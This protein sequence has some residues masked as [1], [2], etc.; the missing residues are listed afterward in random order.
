MKRPN[1]IRQAIYTGLILFFAV[2][3]AALTDSSAGPVTEGV[4]SISSSSGRFLAS[5]GT[6]LPFGFAF[7]AGMVAA[8]N[9]CGFAMLPAYLALF[10][11]DEIN[12]PV[13]IDRGLTRPAIVGLS[14]T[15]GFITTF[16]SF[17]A[18]IGLGAVQLV[19]LF[20]WIGLLVGVALVIAGAYVVSGGSIYVTGP[21]RWSTSIGVAGTRSIRTYF[22]FGIAYGIASLSCT[23][24]IFLAVVGNT[25]TAETWTQS[26]TQF[27]LYGSGMGTVILSITIALSAFKGLVPRARNFTAYAEQIGSFL[28]LSSGGFIVYYW[29]T[30]GGILQ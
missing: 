16:A 21:V 12:S 19:S 3:G 30:I 6:F 1:L 5:V 18:P 17:G 20:P 24:P 23:L 28:L 9:P 25:F 11:G 10:I 8:V 14:M 15:A 22:T 29:L 26:S 4:E 27:L 2:A 13:S 7:T